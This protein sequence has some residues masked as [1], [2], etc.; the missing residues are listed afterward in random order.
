MISLSDEQFPVNI[1]WNNLLAP[2][3][4]FGYGVFNHG[5]RNPNGDIA[6]T[7]KLFFPCPLFSTQAYSVYCIGSMDL[8]TIPVF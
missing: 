4:A 3:V 6:T 1:K 8:P 5:S 2:Q 7:L